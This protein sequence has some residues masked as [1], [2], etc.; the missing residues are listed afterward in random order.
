M[1]LKSSYVFTVFC[2]VVYSDYSIHR[3]FAMSTY[4]MNIQLAL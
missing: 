2:V 1:R 3:L 4:G